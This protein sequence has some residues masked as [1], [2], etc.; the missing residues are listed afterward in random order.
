[1]PAPDATAERLN[2][3]YVDVLLQS[4]MPPVHPM[5]NAR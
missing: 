2:T 1:M 4:L 5:V 3:L